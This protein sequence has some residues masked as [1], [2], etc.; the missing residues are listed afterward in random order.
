MMKSVVRCRRN[1]SAT[2]LASLG[3]AN[4]EHSWEQMHNLDNVDQMRLYFLENVNLLINNYCPE[5]KTKVRLNQRVNVT[6]KLAYLSAE[7]SKA[8][9]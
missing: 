9:K 4:F 6:T 5:T 7:K 3:I 8:Y 1:F 2:N